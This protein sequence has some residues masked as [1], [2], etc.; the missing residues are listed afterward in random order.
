MMQVLSVTT[1]VDTE[2]KRRA[3]R[4]DGFRAFLR[5]REVPEDEIARSIAV[6]KQFEEFLKGLDKSGSLEKAT[7]E[8]INVFSEILIKDDLNVYDN[9]VA[10]AR[11]GR[12][13]ENN[14]IYVAV[15]ELL[16]GSEVF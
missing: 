15:V 12:F 11:Y 9:Y 2:G 4:R 8:D 13:V 14:A 3:M 10:L 5:E 7:S 6:V 16:D 1:V